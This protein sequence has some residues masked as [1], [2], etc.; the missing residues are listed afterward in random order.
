MKS[1]IHKLPLLLLITGMAASGTNLSAQ[2]FSDNFDNNTSASWTSVFAAPNAITDFT[3]QFAFD[4]GTNQFVR[5]GVTN[6]IPAAPNSSGTTKGLKVTVNKDA[7][8]GPAAVSLYPNGQTFSGNFS[9]KFD[10][11]ANYNGSAYGGAESTEHVSFGINHAGDKANWPTNAPS[12][13]VWFLATTEGGSALDYRAL[14]GDGSGN[15]TEVGDPAFPDRDGDEVKEVNATPQQPATHPLKLIFPSPQFESAGAPGKEWVQVEIRQIDGMVTWLMNG[16]LIGEHNNGQ[17]F[18]QSSGNIMLG[19]MDTF[20]GVP[21]PPTDSY[22]IFD[23]VRVFSNPTPTVVTVANNG[24]AAE[25]STP[26]AFRIS[27]SG[28]TSGPLT[29]SYQILGTSTAIAGVDY[30]TLTGTA[31]IPNGSDHVDV[32][33]T[34]INDS[35]QEPSETVVL[36][37]NNNSNYDVGAAAMATVNIDDDGD[38]IPAVYIKAPRDFAYELNPARSGKVELYTFTPVPSNL[39][40]N[41]TLGGTAT[42]GVHYS[43]IPT[44][45]TILSGQ[46]NAI[47]TIAPIDDDIVNADRTVT[48]TLTDNSQATVTIKNDDLPPG[49]LLFSETFETNSFLHWKTNMVPANT[50]GSINFFFDYS[51]VG[52]P[53]APKSSS[54]RGLRLQA[55]ILSGVNGAVNALPTNDFSGDYRLRF[56]MW[57][58]FLGHLGNGGYDNQAGGSGSSLMGGAG[59]G[60]SGNAGQRP[61]TATDDSVW[62]AWLND[63]TFSTDFRAFS[64]ATTASGTGYLEA[65][66]VF[67]AGTG[68]GFIT[69]GR[70]NGNPYY[71]PLG[72]EDPAPAAQLASYPSQTGVTSL[73]LPSMQWRD[74]VI[75]K[76]GSSI[77]WHIDGLLIATVPT[78]GLTLG[79]GKV[80]FIHS[81]INNGALDNVMNFALYDN[82]RVESLAVAPTT[83]NIA[84]SGNSVVLTWTGS[85]TLQQASALTGSPTDWSDV[86]GATSG[87]VVDASSGIK[88]YRLRQ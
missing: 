48:V 8:P 45:A 68:T 82:V 58:N 13:G 77:T 33:V 41:Y 76:Q 51:T 36:W 7:T 42:N 34:P 44:S 71:L 70:D 31:T 72:G 75:T 40:V 23:N 30:Q 85:F 19:Y 57:L 35:W 3:A 15:P 53:P 39:Q 10:M 86:G 61:G 1:K 69:G 5:N 87:H 88:F 17:F 81:D 56:D 65:S 67:A 29:V 64:S 26:G 2:V 66:G 24:N 80:F 63:G 4:Y 49:T 84:R 18:G 59:I 28:S 37:L 50:D 11:W 74:V 32:V 83:L 22:V 14:V 52:I 60:T 6:T 43:T 73:G 55:N 25:P 79:S 21:N 16:Y 78:G 47:I 38:T 46:T 54:T 12:D 9:L 27:R 20:A 62:F